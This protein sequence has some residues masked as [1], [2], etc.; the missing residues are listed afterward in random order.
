M[1]QKGFKFHHTKDNAVTM[2]KWLS[3][4][5]SDRIPSYAHTV[6]GVG[7]LVVNDPSQVLVVSERY[8]NFPHWKLPGGVVDPGIKL[9]SFYSTLVV[10]CIL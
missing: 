8:L 4:H 5:E 2:Y 9:R 7:G 10:K 1:F 6:I 3:E